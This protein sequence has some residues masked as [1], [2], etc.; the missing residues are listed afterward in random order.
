MVLRVAAFNGP[1]Y[2]D[3]SRTPTTPRQT[4]AQLPHME[5][6]R[7]M[8]G[9]LAIKMKFRTLEGKGLDK[10]RAV[11]GLAVGAGRVLLTFGTESTAEGQEP[12]DVVRSRLRQLL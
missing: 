6:K 2:P 12:K 4:H 10:N 5:K 8:V 7:S 11:V 1:P 3:T 9:S